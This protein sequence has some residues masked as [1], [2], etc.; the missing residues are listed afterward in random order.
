MAKSDAE[1]NQNAMAT[2]RG[3][4]VSFQGSRTLNDQISEFSARRT[5][6]TASVHVSEVSANPG[7]SKETKKVTAAKR[8]RRYDSTPHQEV[9]I[10]QPDD[11]LSKLVAVNCQLTTEML[12]AKKQL[13]EKAE[14]ISKLQDALQQKTIESKDLESTNEE[15]ARKICAL[16]R[17]IEQLRSERFCDDLI[18]FGANSALDSGK[19]EYFLLRNFYKIIIQA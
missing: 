10:E 2:K 8:K 15:M 12:V 13:V 5:R 6:R 17:C 19:I 16:E 7:P 9:L 4:H 14:T 3:K 18:D 11:T 1:S